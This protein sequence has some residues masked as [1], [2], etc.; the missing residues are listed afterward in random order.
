VSET[1]TSASFATDFPRRLEE[2]DDRLVALGDRLAAVSARLGGKRLAAQE[3]RAGGPHLLFV[4]SSG[5]YEL[6]E[7]PGSAPAVGSSVQVH[8]R[9]G[10]RFPVVKIAPS[11]L[12]GDVRVCAYLECC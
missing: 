12:P 8:G 9:D 4:P 11:P 6:V 3:S 1:E 10:L 7:A 2:L 5:G